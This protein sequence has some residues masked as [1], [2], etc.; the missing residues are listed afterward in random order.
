MYSSVRTAS[1]DDRVSSLRRV[2]LQT[3]NRYYRRLRKMTAINN[4]AAT[5]VVHLS[6]VQTSTIMEENELVDIDTSPVAAG[7]NRRRLT[8]TISPIPDE[9]HHE[10]YNVDSDKD[11][12]RRRP[13]PVQYETNI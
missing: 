11:R 10:Y 1:D 5:T 2:Q 4:A 12:G 6:D 8:D 13:A 3:A 9:R 7:G